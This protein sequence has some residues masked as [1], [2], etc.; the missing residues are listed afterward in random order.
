MVKIAPIA[1]DQAT[2][3]S[4]EL[5][6][7]W[8][9]QQRRLSE[10]SGLALLL[11]EGHQPPALVV[12]NNNSICEA[13]QSSAEHAALCE[14]YCGEAHQRAL[15]SAGPTHY[16][17]HA[18][19]HCFA[20][21]VQLGNQTGLAMIAGRTFLSAAD[22]RSAAK[23]FSEGDLSDIPKHGIFDN[24]IFSSREVL[25]GLADRL[26]R[27][28]RDYNGQITVPEPSQASPKPSETQSTEPHLQQ[29]IA[30]LQ[31][32]LDSR[33]RF[34]ESL[35][36]FLERISSTDPQAT[37][38]AILNNSRELL[39]AERASLFVFNETKNELNLRAAIGIPAAGSEVQPINIGDGISGAAWLSGKPIIVSDMEAEGL[40]LA[41]QDRQY[42]TRSFISYPIII[43]GRKVGLLN[44]TDKQGGGVYDEVDLSL[45]EIVAPQVALALE[46]AGWQEKATEFQLMSITDPLTGLPNR[47]YLE[48]RLAEEVNRSK[49]YDHEMSFLMI[50]IDDFKVYNDRNG[51]QAGD[52]ALQMTAHALRIAL[53]SADVAAR[54]GGEEFCILL[55]QTSLAE[56]Q[57]IAERV[58]EKIQDTAYPHARLQPLGA[59]TISTG[60]ST[61]THSIDTAEQVIWAADRALYEAK[62]DG[63]NRI[64]CYEEIPLKAVT[65][66]GRS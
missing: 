2:A 44:L 55:P 9:D 20:T 61:L 64:R 52:L 16:R 35:Q 3:E 65:V 14:P 1:Q 18:G 43:N 6:P 15:S 4:R 50:D 45:L 39:R 49:R 42:K 31:A 41:P 8:S 7:E 36:Y 13:I 37:Y 58:R 10:E 5:F 23:R 62:D 22:Y 11:V 30:R 40:T 25:D 63:K 38:L 33:T 46:R 53:R 48:E 59:V 17:C 56:A 47:R 28:V 24:V 32:E 57:V 21:P 34:N 60:I 12:S 54:Y 27:T 66:N 29:E 19:L 26:V 51:H